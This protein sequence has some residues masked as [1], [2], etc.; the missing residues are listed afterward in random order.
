MKRLLLTLSG[1]LFLCI[2]VGASAEVFAGA[3]VSIRPVK[4]NLKP[5]QYSVTGIGKSPLRATEVKI[6]SAGDNKLKVRLLLG[7]GW[8][9]H[10]VPSVR[11]PGKVL[12]TDPKSGFQV[13]DK[14]EK[15]SR[16]I[17]EFSCDKVGCKEKSEELSNDASHGEAHHLSHECKKKDGKDCDEG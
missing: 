17:V 9:E 14:K 12:W 16:N 11:V 4:P 2:I 7:S 15:I 1:G 8:S 10:T 5:P 6:V 13:K 3:G